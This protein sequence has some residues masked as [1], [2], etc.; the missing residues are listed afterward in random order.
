MIVSHAADRARRW[1]LP[2]AQAVA[3]PLLNALCSRIARRHPDALERLSEIRGTIGLVVPRLEPLAV[4]L[5]LRPL[6]AAPHLKLTEVGGIASA[7]AVVRADLPVLLKLLQGRIDGDALFFSRELTVEGDMEIVVALRNAI[8]DARIDLVSE[9]A[10][11]FGPF[12]SPAERLA[13]HALDVAQNF[14]RQWEGSRA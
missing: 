11:L 5:T 10:T 13:R 1:V 6:P 14:Y 8:D 12:T 7:S 9:V 4:L 2:G 3:D